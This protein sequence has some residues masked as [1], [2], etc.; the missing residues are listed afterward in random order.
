ML[1]LKFPVEYNRSR[2]RVHTGEFKKSERAFP[3]Y[4]EA[5]ELIK[6]F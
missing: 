3:R 4:A 5:V 6:Q 2:R 1:H